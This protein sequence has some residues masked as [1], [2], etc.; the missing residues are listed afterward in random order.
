[1][2]PRA[3]P[4]FVAVGEAMVELSAQQPVRLRDVRSFDAGWGGDTSNAAV[5]AA[6]LGRASAYITRVGDDE[7]GASLLDL[8]QREGVDASA[9]RRVAG[10]PTG[11]YLL[12]REA[13][14]EHSFTYYRRGSAAS[15]LEVADLPV[16]LI[17][18]ARVVHTSGIT[19]AISASACDAALAALQTAR[20]SGVLTSYDPNFRPSL[21][22]E[23]R[24]RATF[25]G[26][27]PLV[28]VL[29]PSLDDA[30]VLLQRDDPA[31]IVE[32]LLS[33]GPQVVAL[34]LGPEG[35]LVGDASGITH[36][37][38]YRVAV[39]DPAGAG[40]TF[41]AGFL[42]GWLEGLPAT[43]CTD[44]ANAAAALT[45]TGAGCVA[46]IPTREA[47]ERLRASRAAEPAGAKR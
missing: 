10:A 28:D 7:F 37:E 35:A 2:A 41:D 47:V 27:L 11:I 39:V 45:A 46:P 38:P 24:A 20:S 25:L 18:G 1:M 26:T 43:A 6:R 13:R 12:S 31:A 44:V 5:A 15:T 8:W 19:Q 22:S 42:V 14:H 30:A 32:E 40:D 17:T 33:R 23:Q 9:V 29:L 21:W 4:D 3:A 36:V 34:K 16:D